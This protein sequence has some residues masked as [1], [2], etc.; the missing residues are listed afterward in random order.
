[1]KNIYKFAAFLIVCLCSFQSATAQMSASFHTNAHYSKIGLGYNFNERLWLDGRIY[2]G[3]TIEGI[4]P[5]VS[6]N[7]NFIQRE[8]YETYFGA[9]VV[10]N[11]LNAVVLQS[12]LQ[13][14]PIENLR[15]FSFILE[16]QPQ[17]NWD[18]ETFYF[19][20][21]GGIRYKFN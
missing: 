11:H 10:L 2:S 6:L 8:I 1:M 18:Y 13:L 15:N 4:T 21:F 5:E 20:A 19:N 17:Y 3:T 14:K 12:G 7:Y 9:G 16:A